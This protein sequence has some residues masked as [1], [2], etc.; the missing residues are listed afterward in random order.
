MA[1]LSDEAL[2]SDIDKALIEAQR[3]PLNDGIHG[4]QFK[5]NDGDSEDESFNH[6]PRLDRRRQ[7][8]DS[9]P[10][11]QLVNGTARVDRSIEQSTVSENDSVDGYDS[12]ENTNNKKKRKIPTSGGLGAHHA[13]LS[14]DL[15]NMGITPGHA[16]DVNGDADRSDFADADDVANDPALAGMNGFSGSGR[17]LFGPTN[18]R[19]ASRRSPLGVSANG[20]NAQNNR[21]NYRRDFGQVNGSKGILEKCSCNVIQS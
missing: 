11:R 10:S 6:Y 16:V 14:T 15:A 5:G 17:G 12:F 9:T 19:L 18:N 1:Q 20:T 4:Y 3:T 7:G 2:I 13:S 21:M 8:Q